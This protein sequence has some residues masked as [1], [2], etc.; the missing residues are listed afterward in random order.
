[1]KHRSMMKSMFLVF[2]ALTLLLMGCQNAE[3]RNQGGGKKQVTQKQSNGF[4]PS[5]SGQ[6]FDIIVIND[7]IQEDEGLQALMDSVF[8]KP[9]PALPQREAWFS[10]NTVN[11]ENFSKLHRKHKSVLFLSVVPNDKRTNAL[12]SDELFKQKTLQEMANTGDISI[13]TKWDPFAQPQLVMLITAPSRK[14]LV[15]NIHQYQ[16]RIIEWFDKQETRSIKEKV[17]SSGKN[18][19]LMNEMKTSLGYY[20][21]LPEL[22]E[23]EK[24]YETPDAN[25]K[26]EK[27]GIYS[28]AWYSMGTKETV[29]NVMAYA[30]PYNE[31]SLNKEGIKG[32][33]NDVTKA[34]VKGSKDKSYVSI[35]DRYEDV[36]VLYETELI[37]DKK[38]HIL[39]GLWRM[40]NDFMGGPFVTYVVPDKS[41][42]RI[43]FFDGFVYA[44]GEKKK[45][46]IKR[47]ETILR[48][49]ELP[50]QQ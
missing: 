40:T 39:R 23:K 50:K 8:N 33:R 38:V 13:E 22:Y 46:I 29:Q 41:R 35:E 43:L 4:T 31:K 9:Y 17:M 10:N 7:G 16:D 14:V 20:L 5:S 47:V 30:V 26:M 27:A 24:F 12:V 44:A 6:D 19:M 1:M 48:T 25:A 3:V 21:Q 34:F 18:T 28:Y 37:N 36:P 32:I 11:A 49:F 15:N 45:P 2:S 42:N